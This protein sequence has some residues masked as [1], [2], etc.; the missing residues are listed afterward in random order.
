MC[1]TQKSVYGTES[2][3]DPS[4]GT[5]VPRIPL[6]SALQAKCALVRSDQVKIEANGKVIAAAV[7]APLPASGD[8]YR[9][10]QGNL[11]VDCYL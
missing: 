4:K 11:W 1:S 9:F 6:L 3:G 10:E 2:P 8:G 7:P 5:E